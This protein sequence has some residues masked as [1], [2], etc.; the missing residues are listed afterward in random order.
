MLERLIDRLDLWRGYGAGAYLDGS[1]E[2]VLFNLIKKC[3]PAHEHKVVI[4]AGANIGDFT[5]NI[6]EKLGEK[7]T[8]HA[9]EPAKAVFQQLSARYATDHR[10]ILNN[11]ALGRESETRNLFGTGADTGM[12]SLV[13]RDLAHLGMATAMQEEV[14]VKRLS[15]YCVAASID[16]IVLLKID[17]EGFELEVLKG[18]E[19]LF[20]NR[21]IQL[22]SF[23]F[24]G[25]NLDS[26]TFLRDFFQFFEQ[27]NLRIFR[28]TPNGTL[29]NLP[30]YREQLERFTTTNYVAMLEC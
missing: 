13:K 10:V 5:A 7:V 24:G 19:P 22:C 21:Q 18:A 17:V 2:R 29:V 3:A 28:I 11:C 15:D 20:A 30:R 16:K 12:A 9:F 23:E 27:H 6:L 26:R 4:D 14:E 25:C 8:V 1:G